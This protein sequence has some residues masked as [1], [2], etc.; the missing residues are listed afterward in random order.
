MG[1]GRQH[2]RTAA[3]ERIRGPSAR[4][5]SQERP[6]CSRRRL[7]QAGDR[8]EIGG[9]Q[10]ATGF[11]DRPGLELELMATAPKQTDA[12]RGNRSGFTG[13]IG[14]GLFK[15]A[16]GLMGATGDAAGGRFSRKEGAQRFPL[17]DEHGALL[18]TAVQRKPQGQYFWV[19]LAKLPQFPANRQHKYIAAGPASIRHL[20]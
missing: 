4:A 8:V 20:L 18:W 9:R 6:G 11:D 3:R 2:E 12:R 17:G 15:S 19:S 10:A 1:R 5:V 14:D 13:G 16:D 7:R